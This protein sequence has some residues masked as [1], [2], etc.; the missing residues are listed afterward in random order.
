MTITIW[1]YAML[2][3]F[4]INLAFY[5]QMSNWFFGHYRTITT[6]IGEKITSIVERHSN[7]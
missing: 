7:V 4:A 1:Y 3:L 6:L 5:Q 2:H